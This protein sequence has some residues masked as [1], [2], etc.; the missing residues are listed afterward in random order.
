M[1]D[2]LMNFHCHTKNFPYTSWSYYISEQL[3]SHHYKNKFCH[4]YLYLVRVQK[5]ENRIDFHA[6]VTS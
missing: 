3:I 6:R 5:H 2:S 4:R 1:I